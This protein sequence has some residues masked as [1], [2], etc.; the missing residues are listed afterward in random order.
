MRANASSCRF[1]YQQLSDRHHWLW[2]LPQDYVCERIVLEAA[3]FMELH[4]LVSPAWARDGKPLP[5]DTR[6]DDILVRADAS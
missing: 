3:S 4:F 2:Y 6:L 5:F 1:L